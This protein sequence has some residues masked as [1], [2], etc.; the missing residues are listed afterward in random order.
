LTKVV[1]I[2]PYRSGTSVTCRVLSS[3]GVNFGPLEDLY[4]ASEFN[5]G[6]YFQRPDISRANTE[7]IVSSGGS[8]R[9]PP[10]PSYLLRHP[11]FLSVPNACV[12]WCG[13]S[14][15]DGF[16]DPRFCATLAAWVASGVFALDDLKIIRVRRSY[17]DAAVSCLSHYDV[18]QF[19]DQ[20]LNIA[21]KMVEVYDE[22]AEFQTK[23]LDVPNIVVNQ[24]NFSNSPRS[25]VERISK[26][27]GLNDRLAIESAVENAA[28]CISR[29]PARFAALKHAG[30][31]DQ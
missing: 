20:D 13:S 9:N 18:K 3:L 17:V 1:V 23:F 5:P 29:V 8:L 6:G 12:K 30:D 16:K 11:E 21:L 19:C 26:F 14:N 22:F 4:E 28:L 24:E 10:H 7:F 27:L 25:V 2:G 15:L 31:P